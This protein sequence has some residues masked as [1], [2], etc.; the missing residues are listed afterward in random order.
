[1]GRTAFAAFRQFL[2][3]IPFAVFLF[4]GNDL[5]CARD[6]LVCA[7]QPPQKSQNVDDHGDDASEVEKNK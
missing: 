6:P 3:F 4:A 1:M 5:K 2:R 7:D